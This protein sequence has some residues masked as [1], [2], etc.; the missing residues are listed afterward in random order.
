MFLIIALALSLIVA[1]DKPVSLAISFN[2]IIDFTEV[3]SFE[4][5]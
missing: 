5:S 4:K 3:F 2:N 1:T